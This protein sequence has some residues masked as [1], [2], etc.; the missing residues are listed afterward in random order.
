MALLKAPSQAASEIVEALG[1]PKKLV[2]F[3]LEMEVD[4]VATVTVRYYLEDD[5]LNELIPI[6]KRYAL[7]EITPPAGES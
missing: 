2:S 5:R 4:D 6:L 3:R 7:Q 1:L